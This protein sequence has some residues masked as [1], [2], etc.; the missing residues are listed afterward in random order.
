MRL[1]FLFRLF[2]A[3]EIQL[4]STIYH[5]NLTK[6]QSIRQS[7]SCNVKEF[8][9]IQTGVLLSS[10]FKRDLLTPKFVSLFFEYFFCDD[11]DDIMAYFFL[12]CFLQMM[13]RNLVL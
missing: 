6:T 13:E 4:T 5:R 12:I 3:L 11:H 7:L 9:F 10:A 1:V 2:S 8:W